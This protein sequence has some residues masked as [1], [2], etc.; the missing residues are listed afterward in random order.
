MNATR[1]GIVLLTIAMLPT[2]VWSATVTIGASRDN[3]IFSDQTGRSGGGSP[4][5][6][7]GNNNM[8]G[9]R[10]GLVAFNV[11]AS[12]PAGSYITGAQ[13]TLNVGNS[14]SAGNQS[15]NVFR[16]T[17]DWGEGTAGNSQTTVNGSGGGFT[18]A[19]GDAT[20]NQAVLASTPWASAGGDFDPTPRATATGIGTLSGPV[21]WSSTGLVADVQSWLDTPAAN[22]GWILLSA[23]ESGTDTVRG[24]Y[25]REAGTGATLGIYDPALQP[26]L[27]ITYVPEPTI[28]ALLCIAGPLFFWPRQR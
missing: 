16:L 2:S 27:S 6:F 19:N 21:S 17:K 11:A 5:F 1:F 13:L 14:G 26:V 25:S 18:A 22:F 8:G 20:W 15:I 9:T 23:S 7:V 24:F 12:V 4:G 28:A 10:R 3:T